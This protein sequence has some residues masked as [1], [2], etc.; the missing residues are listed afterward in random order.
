MLLIAYVGLG[1]LRPSLDFFESKRE[2]HLGE[3]IP[4]LEHIHFGFVYTLSDL[5]WLKSLQHF[6]Y[7]EAK[8]NHEKQKCTRHSWLFKTL[9]SALSLDPWYRIIYSAGALGLSV[10]ISDIAGASQ[11]FNQALYY[12]FHD[13]IILY[14]A[15]YHSIYEEENELKGALLLEE[16]AMR[17]APPWVFALSAK[18]YNKLERKELLERLWNELPET[19]S[20]QIKAKILERISQI[21]DSH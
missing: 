20:P 6:D 11:L 8:Q 5:I 9:L 14:K 2:P 18:F 10:I 4:H 17:G 12:Y 21:K 3:P 1:E 13:W 19:L 16:A 15:A 7:C